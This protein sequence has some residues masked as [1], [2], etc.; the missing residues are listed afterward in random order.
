MKV[1]IV[2]D[3]L[4]G[5]G[6]AERVVLELHKLYPDAPIY[7]SQYDARKIDWFKD[8]DVRTGW[9][10]RTPKRLKKF[11][12]LFRAWYFSQLDLSEYDLVISSS[13]AE[14]KGVKTG[15]RT[16]H[17][18]YCHSPTHYYW[19]RT[20]EYLK[21]PGF[22]F[23]FNWAARLALRLLLEPLK[24]WDRQAAKRP[25]VMLANSTHIQT[26]IK[27]Y[28]RRDSTVVFPPVETDRFKIR[29]TAP[30]RHGYV[31]TGRQTP[32]KR[33]D[34]AV[35]AANELKVPLVVIG[36]GP[37]HKKLVKM[38]ER[39]V[40]FLTNVSD[41]EMVDHLQTA[42][43][44]IFPT[45]V[46]DFGIAP[47]EA[48]AAGTPVVAYGKGGPLDY[49]IPGKTGFLFHKLTVKSVIKA[50]EAAQAKNFNP[51][52]IAEHANTF[53]TAA[54]ARNMKVAVKEALAATKA[55]R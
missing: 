9:L 31:V 29:G 15:P 10:Q 36:N 23:G 4:T 37:E 51:T 27:K 38:A 5:V 53:S 24:Q 11:L 6:G 21:N 50:I 32:Y 41:Y 25:D 22:P 12:P 43:A 49:V 34:L 47:V 52:A 1:A 28:Y 17:V 46:E 20:D 55:K 39:N 3:W 40:T 45:N 8:A 42:L 7:T 2:C 54:F 19:F 30:L 44:F 48:M 18:C 33:I 26:M 35:A 14:A 16:T 13:G